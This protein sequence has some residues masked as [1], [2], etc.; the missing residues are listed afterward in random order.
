MSSPAQSDADP[1]TSDDLRRLI[2]DLTADIAGQPLNAGLAQTL[3]DRHG[4]ASP[5]YQA[6][7]ATCE[8]GVAAG[9]LCT[10]ENDG[11]RWGRIFKPADDLHG[12][13]VDVVDMADIAGPHHEHPLGE[14]DL[15]MPQRGDARFDGH[16][17]GWVVY[18]PG[19]AHH[20]TVSAGRALVLYLLPQGQ[21]RFTGA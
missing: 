20:P 12:F 14:I 1:I 10:R 9:W 16:A 21:I 13:S 3:N 6:L 15:V 8:A 2:A 4:V 18:P 7:K 11:I 17:A 19:S 5:T